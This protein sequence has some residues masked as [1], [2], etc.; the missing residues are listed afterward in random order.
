M[1][2]KQIDQIVIEIDKM[3]NNIQQMRPG[4]SVVG[5]LYSV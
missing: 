4:Q 3:L 2:D 5:A 1:F